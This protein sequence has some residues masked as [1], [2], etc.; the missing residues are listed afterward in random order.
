MT[1]LLTFI[2]FSI[3]FTGI[4]LGILFFNRKNIGGECGTVPGEKQGSCRSEEMGL[5]P[6]DDKDGYLR[7][8]TMSARLK[9][10]G[11]NR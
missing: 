1:I 3:C 6:L 5:C 9:N 8:A 10:S 7:M 4:G 11:N 2:F